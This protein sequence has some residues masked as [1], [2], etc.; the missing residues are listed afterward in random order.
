MILYLVLIFCSLGFS[1][2]VEFKEHAVVQGPKILLGEVAVLH[3]SKLE[4]NRAKNI[5]LGKVPR[6]GISQKMAAHTFETF[7][8]KHEKFLN[9]AT[10][11]GSNYVN[12]RTKTK[13]FNGKELESEISKFIREKMKKD[14]AG[15]NVILKSRPDYIEIPFQSTQREYSVGASFGRKGAQSVQMKI[16]QK[17]QIVLTKYFPIILERHAKVA[18][19][20]SP[21]RRGT[22]LTSENICMEDRNLTQVMYSWY[23]N[24]QFIKGQ[25]LR[26]SVQ[27]GRI[28]RRGDLQKKLL[29]RRGQ[30]VSL[31]SQVGSA[32]VSIAGVSQQNGREGEVI[33][34]R[35]SSS[36]R[37]IKARLDETG[38]GWVL[39]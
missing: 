22:V 27:G 18:V 26:R 36:G 1:L 35:N 9:G 15:L 21:L 30:R 19:S 29:V 20:C 23:E 24:P 14:T 2:E 8:L 34:V 11:S 12:V 5:E 37:Y 17:G 33:S 16:F 25:E 32:F 7:Y 10:F 38:K 39:N 3:G 31:V 28:F 4:C 13:N 6:V